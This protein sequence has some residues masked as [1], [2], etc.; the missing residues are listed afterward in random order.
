MP[1]ACIVV[2]DAVADA[3]GPPHE[4]LLEHLVPRRRRQLEQ[5]LC[6]G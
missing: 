6:G 4:R 1:V 3:G 5:L 2:V